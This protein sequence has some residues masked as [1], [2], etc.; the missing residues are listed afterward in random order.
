MKWLVFSYSLPTNL[1]AASRVRIW[2]KLRKSGAV[3]PKLGVHILPYN[4]ACVETVRWLTAEVE[5]ESGEAIVMQV[6]RFENLSDDK[7]I[8][9][10]RNERMADYQQIEAFIAE[11]E[12]LIEAHRLE[13]NEDPNKVVS[14]KRDISKIKKNIDEV[15]RLDFFQIYD[16]HSLLK[17]LQ[18]LQKTLMT[19]NLILL[20]SLSL[21]AFNATCLREMM[22]EIQQ[23]EQMDVFQN[24]DMKH[25]RS[26]LNR[27]TYS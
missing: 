26:Q 24:N 6:N 18:H 22:D 5:R 25:K 12:K 20:I 14:I 27:L 13:Q 15:S 7:V 16:K 8:D 11:L 3:S 21:G 19:G 2:R 10:F 1:T 9:I 17:R 23:E 4:D